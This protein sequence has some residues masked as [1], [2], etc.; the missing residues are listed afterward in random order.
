MD[1]NDVIDKFFDWKSGK[2][3]TKELRNWPG[4]HNQSCLLTESFG[5]KFENRLRQKAENLVNSFLVVE[6]FTVSD[7]HKMSNKKRRKSA[8][9]MG[10]LQYSTQ[11][12]GKFWRE[13]ANQ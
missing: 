10:K 7:E 8:S 9:W 6:A 3:G 5:L 13:M 12:K 4:T 1:L 2:H 11:K